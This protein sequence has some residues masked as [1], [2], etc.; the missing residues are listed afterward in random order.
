MTFERFH[1]AATIAVSLLSLL[2]SLV[3]GLGLA[4]I[5][6]R[7]AG[8]TAAADGWMALAAAAVTATALVAPPE[9][10]VT[11]GLGWTVLVLIAVDVAA[12]RLPDLVTLPLAAAGLGVATATHA[13]LADH[14]VGMAAGFG[15]IAAV[16]WLY[17]RLRGRS[18]I[19]LGDAK[20]FAAA[21]AWLGWRALPAV[22]LIACGG[23]LAWAAAGVLRRGRRAA[24]EPI[25]FGAPLALALWLRWLFSPA[26]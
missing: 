26:G 4:R 13:E 17:A 19:G 16:G 14:V 24:S 15:V 20:L 23:G 11:V 25:P 18:G 22:L 6:R 9:P 7:F 1:N 5:A 3:A 10:A 8:K 12:L 2:A 21:G